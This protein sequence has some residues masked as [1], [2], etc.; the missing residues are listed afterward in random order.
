MTDVAQMIKNE[1]HPEV[2][3]EIALFI[4]AQ[5]QLLAKENEQFR[6]EKAKEDALRQR[7]LNQ[8]V[9]VHLKKLRRRF[10]DIGRESL[11]V[12]ESRHNEQELLMHAQSLTGELKAEEISEKLPIEII[13]CFTSPAELIIQAQKKDPEISI[14]NA[15]IVEINGL[16]EI[17]SEIHITE[18]TY[19]KQIHKRQKYRVKNKISGKEQILTSPGPIKLLPGSRYSIDFALSVV[20]DKFLNHLPYERQRQELLRAEVDVSVSTMYR[21]SEHVAVHLAEIAEKIRE[22]VFKVPLACHLDETP[23][24]ITSKQSD[25]GMMWTLSNQ[26]GS[27]Y[28]FEPTRSG[29][30]ADELLKGYTG[31]VITDK[32][33]GYAHFKENRKWGLC[34]AHARREFFDLL[35]VYP[36]ES[37]HVVKLIDQLFAIERKAKTWDQL[38]ELRQPNRSKKQ[39]KSKKYLK[40]IAQV[41]LIRML[42]AKLFI[43]YSV[44][45]ESS[46]LF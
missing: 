5:S 1:T 41:F 38:K 10:F 18:R 13:Q 2:L 43:M 8:A 36:E 11:G 29:K 33:S 32:Y 24:P 23:W 42:F 3:R 21:L 12:S 16:Y 17:S 45:G 30:I 22:D 34:W 26:A 31:P 44:G 25:N 6:L 9:E 35:D 27:Y 14:A 28:R 15:E 46:P 7:W 37:T 39:T 40:N 20:S 19:V 4:H